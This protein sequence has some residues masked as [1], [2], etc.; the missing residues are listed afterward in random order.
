MLIPHDPSPNLRKSGFV[1]LERE[2]E[3]ADVTVVVI[4]PRQ[5]AESAVAT[6]VASGRAVALNRNVN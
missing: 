2:R 6:P 4:E 5:G 3:L 1:T